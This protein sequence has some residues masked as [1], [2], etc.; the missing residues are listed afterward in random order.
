MSPLWMN[1]YGGEKIMRAQMRARIKSRNNST[2]PVKEITTMT[3]KT[4][5]NEVPSGIRPNIRDLVYIPVAGSEGEIETYQTLT[6]PLDNETVKR[7]HMQVVLVHCFYQL[8]DIT[9]E[10]LTLLI[11]ERFPTSVWMTDSKG[12]AK[13]DRRKYN[14]GMFRCTDGWFPKAG[15]ER[16]ATTARPAATPNEGTEGEGE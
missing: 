9:D 8:P 13:V 16:Y 12:R 4:T 10:E 7:V 11:T 6:P 5:P 2:L 14:G 3:T 15:D 1:R